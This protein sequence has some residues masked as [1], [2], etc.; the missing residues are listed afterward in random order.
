MEQSKLTNRGEFLPPPFFAAAV[1]A[2][3]IVSVVG[4]A[5][6]TEHVIN[7]HDAAGQPVRI[8]LTLDQAVNLA[9]KTNRNIANSQYSAES[10]R[11]S[12]DAPPRTCTYQT[13]GR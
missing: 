6:A 11:Y 1:T 9:L 7:K 3:I 13:G 12:I 5:F 2:A 8:V 4:G 10:Q